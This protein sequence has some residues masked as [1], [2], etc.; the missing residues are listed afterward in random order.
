MTSEDTPIDAKVPLVWSG[1]PSNITPDKHLHHCL[2]DNHV[3]ER[4]SH[5]HV[6]HPQHPKDRGLWGPKNGSDR[7]QD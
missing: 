2:S 1:T 5:L 7:W 3:I 6:H 4:A